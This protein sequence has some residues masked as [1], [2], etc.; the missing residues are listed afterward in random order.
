MT[1]PPLPSSLQFRFATAFDWLIILI[2]T[3]GAIA[4]GTALPLLMFYFGDLVNVLVNQNVTAQI[5][6]NISGV[7][8]N[9]STCSMIFPNNACN[10]T[11]E[12]LFPDTNSVGC[13]LDDQFINEINRLTFIF[14]GFGVGVFIAGYLQVSLFQMAAERQVHKIRLLFYRAILHQDIGWFDA[15]PSGEL[16][17][18]LSEYVP[19]LL[20]SSLITLCPIE[21]WLTK[22]LTSIQ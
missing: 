6:A 22:S 9:V 4:H 18:R 19:F 13:L 2:G 1:P 8:G 10:F 12:S 20:F 14:V 17:S 16:S 15:N 7:C 21:T 3:L 11:L 5:L